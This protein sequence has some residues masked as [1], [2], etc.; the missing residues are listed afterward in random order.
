MN[1]QEGKTII[2]I[3]EEKPEMIEE[4]NVTDKINYL[5]IK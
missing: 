3:V 4:I 5:G 1:K 2:C